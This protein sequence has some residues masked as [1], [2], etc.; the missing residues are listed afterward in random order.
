MP[1]AANSGF[2]LDSAAGSGDKIAEQPL[3]E[4]ITGHALWMPLNPDHPIRI[5]RP[6]EAFDDAIDCVRRDPQILS[7]LFDGLMMRAV[8]PGLRATRNVCQAAVGFE[9]RPVNR[10]VRTG[11]LV[12]LTMSFE[13]LIRILKFGM[14]VLD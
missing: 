8:D 7:G 11:R 1:L 14:N 9:R 4:R 5:A 12:L 2:L 13:L 3:G 10:I 6:F